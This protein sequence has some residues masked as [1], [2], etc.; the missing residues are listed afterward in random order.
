MMHIERSLELFAIAERAYEW[1]DEPP[2][3]LDLLKE[4][5]EAAGLCNVNEYAII[6]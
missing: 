4:K 2:T 3:H 5:I 1:L 6:Y